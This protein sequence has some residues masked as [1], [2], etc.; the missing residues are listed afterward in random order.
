[1][2]LPQEFHDL[3]AKVRNWGR[4]GD[5]DRI[6]TLNHITPDAIRRG[7]DAI[8]DGRAISLAVPL[9]HD[10]VQIGIIPGR[11]NPLRTMVA[12]NSPSLGDPDGF[13]TSDD[14]VFMGLQAGTHWD[15][16]GHVSYGGKL[17]NGFEASTIDEWGCHTL[18]IEHVKHLSTRGVLLDVARAKGLD[19]LEPAYAITSADLDAAADLGGVEVQQGDVVLIRTGRMRLYHEGG[20]MA[21]CVGVDG[22]GG[23][24]GPSLD[25]VTWFHDKQV[26][27]VANDTLTFEVFPSENPAAMLAIHLLHIVEMGLTQGQN[28]DLESLAADCAADGRYTFFLAAN[29]EPFVGGCG[30]PVNPV[31]VK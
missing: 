18:G 1:M 14:V 20:G 11:V 5:N 26:A 2:P 21:Y 6:G 23:N 10:G 8:E 17:Y 25:T 30:S 31:A 19:M 3:A 24:A 12:I 9:K 7:R 16:L 4:W 27:A 29:P 13:C 15:G 28:F 22:Q